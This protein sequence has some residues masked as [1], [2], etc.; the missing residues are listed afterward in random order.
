[1]EVMSPTGGQFNGD[2]VGT[3]HCGPLCPLLAQTLLYCVVTGTQNKKSHQHFFTCFRNNDFF[4]SMI[5][6]T[7]SASHHW[8]FLIT[9]YLGIIRD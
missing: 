5:G 8:I 3:V 9:P 2:V 7:Y 4:S 1:M 6:A